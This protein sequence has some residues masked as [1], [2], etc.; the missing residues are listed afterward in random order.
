MLR[1]REQVAVRRNRILRQLAS[2]FKYKKGEA[3][4][5]AYDL[6]NSYSG[7]LHS[8]LKALCK[9]GLA[10]RKKAYRGISSGHWEYRITSRGLEAVDHA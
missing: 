5:R 8:D 9:L 3:W 4:S 10:E 2:S 7:T 6:G 1:K